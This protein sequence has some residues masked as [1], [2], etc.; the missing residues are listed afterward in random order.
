[1][2]VKEKVHSCFFHNRH[3]LPNLKNQKGL[4]YG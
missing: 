4:K 3:H 2:L 1:M